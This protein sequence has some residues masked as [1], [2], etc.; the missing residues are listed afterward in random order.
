MNFNWIDW[1]IVAVVFYYLIS[2]W[3]TGLI[4]LSLNLFSFLGSLWFAVKFHAPVGGFLTEKFGI[5]EIWTTVLGYVVVAIIAEALLSEI[6]NWFIV[7]I[8]KK[9]FTSK[10]NQWLGALLATLNGIVIVTF[11]L[12]VI[13]ALPLRG[14]IKKDISTSIIGKTLVKYAE[15][16]GGGVKSLLEEVS[17]EAR[18][19][20]TIQPRST[21]R[22]ELDVA[23]EKSELTIDEISENR[24][25]ELVNSERAK[26][27]APALIIDMKITAVARAHSRDMFE[28][29]Y[30]SH[31]SPEGTDVG[32]RLSA[33]G[34]SFTYAGE[35]LAYAP[36]LPTAHQGLMD[37]E[38]HRRNILDPE[39]RRIGIG[40][41][42]GGIYGKI[43]TQN[44]TN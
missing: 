29:A 5:P 42:D 12:L 30:F 41:I 32:D 16:Y 3:Q 9:Y 17:A 4:Y 11:I 24:M 19:F 28:R 15:S 10:A 34:V 44:F 7:K 6:G 40:V 21:E 43:F 33:G 23:P 2:G 13:L 18:K 20:L 1:T 26:V 14:S 38:E 25:V 39:F 36:D 8:P 37:S 22:I 35:N 31:I 27:G